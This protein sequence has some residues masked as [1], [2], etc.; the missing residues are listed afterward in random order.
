ME[1]VEGVMTTFDYTYD[2]VG[3]LDTVSQGGMVVRDYDYDDNGNRTSLD[4]S[5][6]VTTGVYDDQDRLL[7]YGD[8]VYEYRESGELLSKI[9]TVSGDTTMYQY[10]ELGRPSR[11]TPG[12]MPIITPPITAKVSAGPSSHAQEIV[13]TLL[14]NA[15]YESPR[16]GHLP[17]EEPEGW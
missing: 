9:D 17:I 3:R 12:G 1:I 14:N 7:T 2:P 15:R 16:R 6:V 4:E 13:T 10:D 11:M 5:G 8:F